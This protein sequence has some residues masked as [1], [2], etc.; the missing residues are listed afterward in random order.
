MAGVE[1]VK[2]QSTPKAQLHYSLILLFHMNGLISVRHGFIGIKTHGLCGQH[3]VTLL[4]TAL[5]HAYQLNSLLG[6]QF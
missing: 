1:S 3:L 6:L 4:N 5:V 2:P